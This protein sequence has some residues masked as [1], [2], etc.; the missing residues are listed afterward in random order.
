MCLC[1]CASVCVCRRDLTLCVSVPVSH[2][3]CVRVCAFLWERATVA[4]TWSDPFAVLCNTIFFTL[5]VTPDISVRSG[6]SAIV[7]PH[8][9]RCTAPLALPK[10]SQWVLHV[11]ACGA[12]VCAFF[13]ER[14]LWQISVLP[15]WPKNSE[16]CE[17]EKERTL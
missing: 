13:G 1:A 15:T 16:R 3:V 2:S 4:F 12:R 17:V 11:E 7:A 9:K 5:R 6:E 10:H 14:A 8:H